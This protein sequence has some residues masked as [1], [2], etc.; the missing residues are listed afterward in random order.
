VLDGDHLAALRGETD[1]TLTEGQ[2]HNADGFLSQT[3]RR[4]QRQVF[5]IGVAQVDTADVCVQPL[6]DQIGDI[7]QR[8]LEIVRPR[9][10]LSDV[11]QD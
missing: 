8:L 6:G 10:D 1:Q 4:T 7:R 3:N 9:D 5:Q 11:C 2:A